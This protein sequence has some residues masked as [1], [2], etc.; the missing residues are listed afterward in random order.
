MNRSQVNIKDILLRREARII[1]FFIIIYSVGIAGISNHQTSGF[2]ISLIPAIILLSLFICLFFHRPKY[3]KRTLTV[4]L[5]VTILAFMVEAIGV[6]SGFL[7]GEYS[8][9]HSL[10]P[11]LSGTP[12]LIGLNW[13]FLV[14]C[15]A[16]ISE[17]I[18]G[19][20]I[21]K[22][23]AASSLMLVYDLFLEI[24]APFLNMWSFDEGR[25][26]VRNFVSWFLFA[27]LFH[28]LLKIFRVRIINTPAKWI[29]SIQLL[30]FILLAIIR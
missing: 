18:N 13:L 14:Y 9:G 22:I 16:A 3:D 5:L 28:S 21:I 1:L 25:I 7:F 2:F 23:V 30:F 20:K 15:T 11:R 17:N 8:Y 24:S 27:V 19:R 10:G 6:N 29:F 26:P 4:F 12:L